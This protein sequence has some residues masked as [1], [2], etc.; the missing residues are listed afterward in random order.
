MN[1]HPIKKISFLATGSEILS[2]DIHELNMHDFS[3]EI[4][5]RGG[6][7][8]QHVVCSDEKDEMVN[9]LRYL[10]T[11]SDVVLITG[12][13]GPTSDDRTR[14][15]LA[16]VLDEEL[17]LSE[18]ALQHIKDR[19]ARFNHPF[20]EGQKQQALFPKNSTLIINEFGS[21]CGCYSN[22]NNKL[23]FMLPGPPRENK[24]MFAQVVLPELK[25]FHCF[26]SRKIY[27]WL[28]LGLSEGIIGPE[29]DALAQAY[30]NVATG[31]RWSYPYLEIKVIDDSNAPITPLL[32][33][34]ETKLAPRLISMH[35][36]SA[37]EIL[38]E[39]LQQFSKP[40]CVIDT[41]TESL[42][43]KS[44]VDFNSVVFISDKETNENT[45]YFVLQSQLSHPNSP[46]H[47]EG[48][49]TYSCQ[50]FYGNSLV[51]EHSLET[52]YRGKEIR[53]FALAYAQWQLGLFLGII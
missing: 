4:S 16:E 31:F 44:L 2:G 20:G 39:Q 40:L 47:F 26:T 11:H 5:E 34:I 29:I 6:I 19:L 3:H 42:L 15:A 37:F 25:K 50:G 38:T 7:L 51:F 21:A 53:E 35:N 17:E 18:I 32:S 1:Q 10:L 49:I 30:S 9:A 43:A 36:Q 45:Y 27:R 8:F 23:I 41:I 52:P 33:A 48:T 12:G 13:L 14:Y 22:K 24:P 28:T 46:D